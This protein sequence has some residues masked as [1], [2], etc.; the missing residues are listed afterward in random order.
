MPQD[1][2]PPNAPSIVKTIVPF[3]NSHGLRSSTQMNKNKDNILEERNFL[4]PDKHSFP[5]VNRNETSFSTS[6][7]LNFYLTS[8]HGYSIIHKILFRNKKLF[9]NWLSRHSEHIKEYFKQSSRTNENISS[10]TTYSNCST[11]INKCKCYALLKVKKFSS[12]NLKKSSNFIKS[13]HYPNSKGYLNSK[14]N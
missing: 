9:T 14:K 5:C 6:K 3:T 12:K 7:A 11:I 13:N 1:L 10:I 2:L 8:E 4:F